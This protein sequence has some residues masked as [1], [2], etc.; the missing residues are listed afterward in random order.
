VLVAIGGGASG[1]SNPRRVQPRERQ[2]V[3]ADVPRLGEYAALLEFR[4]YLVEFLGGLLGRLA[5][6][7]EFVF[8]L[9]ARAGAACHVGF[10]SDFVVRFVDVVPRFVVGCHR[11]PN[12]ILPA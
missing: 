2:L 9:V 11:Y 6:H 1:E 5:A 3:R 10:E 4:H 7:L 8:L 12:H